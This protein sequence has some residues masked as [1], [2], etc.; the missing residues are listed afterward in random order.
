MAIAPPQQ[1]TPD[2][3]INHQIRKSPVRLIDEDG[4][5]LGIVP[6]EEARARAREKGLD[7][8]E[9]GGSAD[10][11]VC[12]ILDWGKLRY[13][14]QKKEREAKKKTFTI[15]V[16]EV[17]YRPTIDQHDR[18]RKTAL[19]RGFL[20]KGNKVKVT[21]FFRFRQ[22]R[23]P[24]LGAEILDR[25][26]QQLADIAVVEFRTRGMEG[27]Q[28]TMILAPNGSAEKLKRAQAAS[29]A[30]E[31]ENSLAKL[32]SPAPPAAAPAPAPEPE[33]QEPKADA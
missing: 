17:K 11:P 10:P 1:K 20:S 29:E 26:T 31:A 18:D 2:A 4:T 3:R 15:E 30:A 8:V 13:E 6:V 25:V 33:A 16:K 22:L 14:K 23:R 27:R 32:A 9:V 28:M 24:E 19:A 12:R 7:L 21:V 5:Q